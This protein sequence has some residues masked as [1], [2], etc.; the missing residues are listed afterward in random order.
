MKN[1]RYLLIAIGAINLV[2]AA[3]IAS[4]IWIGLVCGAA[5]FAALFW[6]GQTLPKDSPTIEIKP[7]GLS[8]REPTPAA[9][10][11]ANINGL[12]SEV[13]PLWNR[14]VTLAQ[15]QVKEAIESLAQRFASLA[16]RLS[17]SS[18]A[19]KRGGDSTALQTIREAE[20]GLRGII[21][22]LNST[23]DFRSALVN[24][25]AG[26]ASHTDDLR[27]MAEE[28]ANIA[29]QTNLLALNAAIEAARAGESGRGFAV[30][31]DEVRK[32]S[33]QS[34]ETG[35]RIHDTVNTVSEAIA[36]ALQLSEQF[37]S[38]E[39]TAIGSSR[40]TAETIISNFNATAQSLNQSLQAMQDERHEVEADVSEVLVNLQFQDRV[41]QIL[42]HVLSDMDRLSAT[43]KTLNTT[44]GTPAPNTQDWLATLSRSYTMHEQRQQHAG[45]AS[46]SAKPAGGGITF[47]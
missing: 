26:V 24:E 19:D 2:L 15:G 28:V 12:V 42:D 22:T 29:K 4:N 32:L 3:V 35:K 20:E 14:H 1:S 27:K 5:A 39:A 44:P 31:A 10:Q 38:R 11:N 34:G 17:S 21:D 46:T 6:V 36:Q 16:Q 7:Q 37:A 13:V 40:Q 9:A 33:T 25:V 43:A 41:H 8:F 45:D 18:A 30:V 47:F 23:Q